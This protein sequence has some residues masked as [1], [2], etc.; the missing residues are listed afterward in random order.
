ML[1]TGITVH[2]SDFTITDPITSRVSLKFDHEVTS[3]SENQNRK[4]IT[5]KLKEICDGTKTGVRSETP[6][7]FTDLVYLMKRADSSILGSI[8]KMLTE[9]AFCPDNLYRTR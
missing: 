1:F 5:D 3:T 2:V 6:K 8:H 4:D 9:Q 7:L